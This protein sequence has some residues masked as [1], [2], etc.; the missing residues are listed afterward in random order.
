VKIVAFAALLFFIDDIA[1]A[2]SLAENTGAE[3]KQLGCTSWGICAPDTVNNY[4][5][6]LRSIS[7]EMVTGADAIFNI[8]K[9]AR[10]SL[11]LMF[12]KDCTNMAFLSRRR[13]RYI[14]KVCLYYTL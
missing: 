7:F 12:S 4:L 6:W 2:I 13:L 5:K 9:N 8:E 14:L 10:E 3:A 1:Y 11:T